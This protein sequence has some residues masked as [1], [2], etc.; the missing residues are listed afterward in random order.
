MYSVKETEGYMGAGGWEGCNSSRKGLYGAGLSKAIREEFRKNGIKGATI[1]CET[2]PGGQSV[3]IKLK[4]SE[5]DYVPFEEYRLKKWE[6]INFIQFGDSFD[7]HG[8]KIDAWSCSHLPIKGRYSL[9]EKCLVEHYRKIHELDP[10]YGLD[11][12]KRYLGL[13]EDRL[14]QAFLDKVRFVKKIVDS[15]NYDCSNAMVDYHDKGF[16][17]TYT[18]IPAK[19][20]K[21]EAA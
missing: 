18:L 3:R 4:V 7:Y 13:Y 17:D 9:Y 10:K 11:I 19:K 5:D 6:C 20:A 1:S 8:R 16:C 12:D 15:F 21:K 2:Y 14:S